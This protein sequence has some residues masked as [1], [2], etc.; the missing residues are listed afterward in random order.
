MEVVCRAVPPSAETVESK[1]IK[2]CSTG[3]CVAAGI[4][5]GVGAAGDGVG[6]GDGAA[7]PLD[8][9]VD[10]GDFCWCLCWS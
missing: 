1:S 10:V 5:I 8:D 7:V 3:G 2:L 4:G 9:G 6:A